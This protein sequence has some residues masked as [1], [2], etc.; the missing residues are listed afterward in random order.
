MRIAYVCADRGVPAFGMKGCSLHV[1]EVLRAFRN[2][3]GHVDLFTASTMG[4]PP[5][6]LASITTHRLQRIKTDNSAIR[7]QADQA[8]N[9]DTLAMLRDTGPFDLV[10]ERYSL[11]SH[12]GMSH[13][14]EAGIPGVL[15]VNAPLIDEQARYRGLIDQAG[16][17]T[18]A[19]RCF[20][21][22]SVLVAV[23][24]GVADYLDEFAE[25]R[26]KIHVVPNG[27]NPA[28][29]AGKPDVRPTDE[30]FTI[31]FVGTLKPWHGLDDLLDAFVLLLAQYPAARLLVVGDGPE[32]EDLWT[33]VAALG[34]E[35]VVEMTGAVAPD[36]I[37]AQLARMDA[38]VAPYPD[39][40]GFYFSPL[41]VYEYMAAGL[42]VVASRVGQLEELVAD[43][44]SGLLYP[45]GNTQALASALARLA[46]DRSLATRLGTNGRTRSLAMHTWDSRVAHILY[47]AGLG[48]K[49]MPQGISGTG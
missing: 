24:S 29:F 8:A 37:P 13:A 21:A 28:R 18:T 10:Y 20:G 47:L 26:G 48:N 45:A 17:V 42:P 9:A 32:A 23:S 36:D 43:G 41:K 44:D 1:Q 27:V 35:H 7:E 25:T 4:T 15:E 39:Y 19:K 2:Q 30:R 5:Q 12:A 40:P 49:M 11:W 31:G 34:L 38:G 14:C 16:A 33:R 22:A 3:G 46:G 6:G